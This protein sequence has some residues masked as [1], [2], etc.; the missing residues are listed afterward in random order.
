MDKEKKVKITYPLVISSEDW[1]EFK[2]TV[3]R[4]KSLNDA[5]VDA[6]REKTLKE[7]KK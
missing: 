1:E 6:I 3:P 4:S 5:V 2:N 7:Q